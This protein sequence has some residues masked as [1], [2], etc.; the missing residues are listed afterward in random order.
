MAA[1]H[2]PRLLAGEDSFLPVHLSERLCSPNDTQ[3]T[4]VMLFR[5]AGATTQQGEGDGGGAAAKAAPRSVV[6]F[7]IPTFCLLLLLIS[8]AFVFP[9]Q[10]SRSA[11]HNVFVAAKRCRSQTKHSPLHSE[12]VLI[13]YNCGEK[14]LA[15]SLEFQGNLYKL[16]FVSKII[17]REQSLINKESSNFY[18]LLIIYLLKIFIFTAIKQFDLHIFFF[19]RSRE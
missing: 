9:W 7:F 19:L 8:Q 15:V 5:P 1:R 16:S 2:L 4:S 13:Y 12:L 11:R 3:N 18:Y 6:S 10:D 14:N 17:R